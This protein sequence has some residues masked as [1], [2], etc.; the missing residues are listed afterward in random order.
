MHSLYGLAL[1]LVLLT[2]AFWNVGE[3]ASGDW[4]TIFSEASHWNHNWPQARIVSKM[5]YE[6]TLA[7]RFSTY[8]R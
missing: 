3:T 2:A 6:N 1:P 8:Q 4:Q 5:Q 7:R